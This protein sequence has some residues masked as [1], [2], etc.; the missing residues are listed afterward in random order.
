MKTFLRVQKFLQFVARLPAMYMY[1]CVCIYTVYILIRQWL[2]FRLLSFLCCA[3][4]LCFSTA[5]IKIFVWP[6]IVSSPFFLFVFVLIRPSFLTWLM[7][8]KNHCYNCL[9]FQQTDKQK[10]VTALLKLRPDCKC[11]LCSWR[12]GKSL[13]HFLFLYIYL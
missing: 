6:L 5:V 8:V 1:V 3:I 2:V 10:K 12:N 7:G 13:L 9:A 11:F 4:L